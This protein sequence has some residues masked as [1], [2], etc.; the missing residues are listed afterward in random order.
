[1][2]YLLQFIGQRQST[3]STTSKTKEETSPDFGTSTL[4]SASKRGKL[5][6]SGAADGGIPLCDASKMGNKGHL[7]DQSARHQIFRI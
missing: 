5:E 6:S 3:M 1:M 2:L 7:T 4:E